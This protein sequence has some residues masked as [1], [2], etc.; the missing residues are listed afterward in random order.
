MQGSHYPWPMPADTAFSPAPGS[1]VLV[2]IEPDGQGGSRPRLADPDAPHLLL[3]DQ[4]VTRGDGLFETALAVAD[5][6]GT[7]TMRKLPAHLGRLASSAEAL[8]LP[9]PSAAV[10]E[11]AVET[12]LRAHAAVTEVAP[13]ARLSVRLTATRGPEVPAGAPARPRTAWTISEIKAGPW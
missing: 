4:G 11:D 9:V 2:L 8:G 3:T 12:G 1:P 7:L 10:W 6:A 13:G 5:D